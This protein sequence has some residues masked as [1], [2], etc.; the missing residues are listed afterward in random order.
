MLE[1]FNFPLGLIKCSFYLVWR[2]G[3]RK[4]LSWDQTTWSFCLS[5]GLA[6]QIRLS[7]HHKFLLGVVCC[8]RGGSRKW[9]SWL[10]QRTR[11]I[12][13][14]SSLVR[15]YTEFWHERLFV[16]VSWGVADT[17]LLLLDKSSVQGLFVIPD[18]YIW[19]KMVETVSRISVVWS[20]HYGVFKNIYIY[21][22]KK[23]YC[24]HC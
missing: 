19:A 18:I 14:L 8:L 5:C 7:W 22:Y 6:C 1:H 13:E 9:Q 15:K 21:V 4:S 12:V 23:L 17:T 2:V 11:R 20:Q 3:E 24:R 10:R 16:G